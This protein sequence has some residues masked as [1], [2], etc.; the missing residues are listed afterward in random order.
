MGT[1]GWT[2]GEPPPP[3]ASN[4]H[5]LQPGLHV[6]RTQV[7]ELKGLGPGKGQVPPRKV[8]PSSGP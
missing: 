4:H 7:R 6:W 5:Q 2:R 8:P 1:L 3:P